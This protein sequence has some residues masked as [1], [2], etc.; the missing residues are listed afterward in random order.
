MAIE[1]RHLLEE[2]SHMPIRPAA[3]EGG[4]DHLVFWAHIIEGPEAVPYLESG[5]LA[6]TTGAAMSENV[7]ER[8]PAFVEEVYKRDAAGILINIGPFIRE[9]PQPVLDFCNA[10]EFPLFTFPWEIHI[11][12]LMQIFCFALA[13]DKQRGSETIGAMKSAILFPEQKELYTV[14]LSQADFQADWNYAA[15]VICLPDGYDEKQLSLLSLR[16]DN[17]LQHNHRNSIAFSLEDELVVVVGNME[18]KKLPSFVEIIRSFLSSFYSS[19][20][21]T[22]GVGQLM[23]SVQNISKSYSQA[24]QIATLH[25]QDR[26]RPDLIFYSD[27]GIYKLL[28]CIDDEDV[29]REYYDQ[30]IRP[31]MDYDEKNNINLTQVV[32]SY[33]THNGSVNEVAQE[34]YLHRN[35]INY[36]IKRAEEVLQ[37]NLSHHDARFRLRMGFLIRDMLRQE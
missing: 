5:E 9:I 28:M 16:L 17:Y 26:I 20:S 24:R 29:L 8:L 34:L 19:L 6:I 14:A 31:L 23:P 27:M 3:G 18:E 7:S 13:R 36:R 30:T 4:L 35:T 32:D 21:Y 10:N 22:I 15:I 37:M 1:L 12:E 25:A 11:S 33:L 2:T